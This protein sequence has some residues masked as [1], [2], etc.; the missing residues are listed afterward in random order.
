MLEVLI[1]V[2]KNEKLNDEF[3]NVIID[4]YLK[5]MQDTNVCTWCRW[6]YEPWGC[7]EDEQDGICKNY[8]GEEEF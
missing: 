6:F 2:L 5:Y 4:N 1:D 3:K 7:P 8:C